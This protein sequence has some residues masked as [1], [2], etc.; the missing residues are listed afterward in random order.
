MIHGTRIGS[1]PGKSN[2]G[3][4]C[5]LITRI[6]SKLGYDRAWS[7]LVPRT[8]R[9]SVSTRS[10]SVRQRPNSSR[11]F[12]TRSSFTGWLEPTI[13][14][15]NARCWDWFSMWF[16]RWCSRSKAADATHSDPCPCMTSTRFSQN[17]TA[18]RGSKPAWASNL[19]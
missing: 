15:A 19:A 13:F 12:S 5:G 2:G 10:R 14:N 6:T 16:S 3:S 17:C 7:T 18:L 9:S 11:N 1:V 8:A 4:S